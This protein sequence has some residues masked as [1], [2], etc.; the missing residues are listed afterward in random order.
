MSCLQ[1]SK[2]STKRPAFLA[3]GE[4]EST[5]IGGHVYLWLNKITV[6]STD[7]YSQSNLQTILQSGKS[8]YVEE[9]IETAVHG[10]GNFHKA[11]KTSIK[12]IFSIANLSYKTMIQF[13]LL[14]L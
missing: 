1:H 6:S 7:A 12:S 14:K 8:A 10:D 4:I 13:I 3:L 9:S 5:S 2:S 11:T